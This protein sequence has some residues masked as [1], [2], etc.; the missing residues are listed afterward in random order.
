MEALSQ[1]RRGM[2]WFLLANLALVVAAV[3]LFGKWDQFVA[4]LKQASLREILV[5]LCLAL[6]NYAIRSVRFWHLN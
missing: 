3:L 6:V 2:V 1:K 4:A 5:V